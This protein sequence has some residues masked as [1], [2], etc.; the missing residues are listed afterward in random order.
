MIIF[1]VVWL[2][3]FLS[4]ILLNRLLR[5]GAA[6]A[7]DRDK[8]SL[9]FLWLTIGV[10]NILG[11][12]FSIFIRVP[13]SQAIAVPFSG[14][15]LIV[16][17]MIIRFMAIRSL[18]KYFTVDVTIRADHKIKKDGMYRL[19]R[20]PAYLGSLISFLGFG[21]SLNNWFSLVIIPVLVTWAM[22]RRIR[23][24]ENVL[25]D[26]FGQEYAEYLNSTYRLIPYIF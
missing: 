11:V 10:A 8:G 19:I 13:L 21:L 4:E 6:D 18:G 5:S 12:F 2:V 9:G 1:A 22:L 16:A 3:W 15:L 24:E 26:R 14:L 7:K 25:L 23:I 17:G 20:H